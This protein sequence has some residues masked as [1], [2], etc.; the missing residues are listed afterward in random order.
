MLYTKEINPTHGDTEVQ[1][2]PIHS[3]CCKLLLR[4]HTSRS[5]SYRCKWLYHRHTSI[6]GSQCKIRALEGHVRGIRLIKNID[7]IFMTFGYYTRLYKNSG[8]RFRKKF[9]LNLTLRTLNCCWIITLVKF[10]CGRENTARKIKKL[11]FSSCLF[12]NI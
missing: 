3:C 12:K 2:R 9:W 6:V 1:L 7:C 4:Y 5:R 10:K 8:E 11:G